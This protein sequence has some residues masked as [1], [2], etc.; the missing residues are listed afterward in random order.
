MP[1]D[2]LFSKMELPWPRPGDEVFS[3]AEDQWMNAHVNWAMGS[4]F[5][6]IG[7]KTAGDVLVEHVDR[8]NY[9]AD[10]LVYPV[11]FCYRQYLELTLKE[12][13]AEARR[14]FYIEDEGPD[15]HPLLLVWWPLRKLLAQRWSDSDA[16]TEMDAVE[17]ALRQFDTVDRGSFAF[18]YATKKNGEASLPRE[19]QRINLRNLSEVVGRIGTYLEACHTVLSEERA[20]ADY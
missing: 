13:L 5:Y 9:D 11:V 7:Y 1:D 8:T 2:G 10:S 3:E 12:L 6:A 19:L 16:S 14:Y 18:R 4:A 20:A 17:D 15:G